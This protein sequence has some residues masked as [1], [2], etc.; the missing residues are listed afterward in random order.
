MP[1]GVDCMKT[2]KYAFQKLLIIVI[3]NQ[4]LNI[5]DIYVPNYNFDRIFMT[6]YYES[7]LCLLWEA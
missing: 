6:A 7:T 3:I 2:F 4:N 1:I 5:H